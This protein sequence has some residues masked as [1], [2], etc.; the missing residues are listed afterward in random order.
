MHITRFN[1]LDSSFISVTNAY[2]AVRV[3]RCVVI[4]PW[5]FLPLT[6]INYWTGHSSTG[7][8][9]PLQP[10]RYLPYG[11]RCNGLV[12][13]LICSRHLEQSRVDNTSLPLPAFQR[14]NARPSNVYRAVLPNAQCATRTGQWS[15]QMA[16]MQSRGR[17]SYCYV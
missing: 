5:L 17:Q 15:K 3:K 1:L 13:L 12:L 11:V 8:Q 7:M 4:L 16:T 10:K 9:W 2:F 6:Y 14:L